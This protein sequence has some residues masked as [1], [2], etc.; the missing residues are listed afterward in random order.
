MEQYGLEG[1]RNTVIISHSGTGKTSLSEAILFASGAISRLGRVE[2]G[3]TTSD[4]DPSEIRRKISLSLSIIPCHWKGNKINFL[5][6]PGYSDFVGE[7]KAGMRVAE[8]AVILVCA[9]SGVEVGTEQ[10]WE[11]CEETK[12]PR[13]IFVNKMDREN[14]DFY[15]T[16]EGL[17]SKFGSRCLPFQ[18]PIG[19]ESDFEGLVDVLTGKTY[20]G[21]ESKE[22]PSG[23]QK[24][25][26]YS[27][28]KLVEAVAE[29][30]DKLL[31]KYLGGEELSPEEL[32][33]GLRGAVLNGKIVPV[34][35]GSA[36][37]NIGTGLLLD[38][39]SSFLPSPK[40]QGVAI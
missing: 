22:I 30:D 18:L 33:T 13:L 17:K 39:V 38:T 16:V 19:S 14:A 34:L 11:Y 24:E 4:Y 6:T 35:V 32:I 20:I 3:T 7:V 10:V 25:V 36:I 28:E 23:L 1:I 40:E 26:N 31:E 15:R 8:G 21:S 37:K 27:R 2:D 9:A 29:L 5:D 12:L